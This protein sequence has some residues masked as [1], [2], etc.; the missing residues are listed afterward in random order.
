MNA[1]VMVGMPG[2]GKSTSVAAIEGYEEINRDN[3][4]L[5]LLGS[6]D[7]FTREAWINREHERRIR[8][9]ADEGKNVVISDT[10]TIRR[11]RRGLI[12][13]LKELG[14][15]VEVHLF[16]VSLETCLTRNKTRSKPVEEAIIRKMANR[17]A[18]NPP[19]MDEGMDEIRIVGA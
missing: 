15:R 17:L 13:L 8:R 5:E 10:N 3:L 2:C 1:I 6:Y 7:D 19:T 9:A 14:F 16:D 4:R 12:R 18:L 11:Y